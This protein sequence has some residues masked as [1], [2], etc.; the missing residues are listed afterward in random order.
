VPVLKRVLIGGALS[1]R[2]PIQTI[3]TQKA[4]KLLL[5]RINSGAATVT[6]RVRRDA[7]GVP[8]R[9]SKRDQIA[10]LPRVRLSRVPPC[11]RVNP[12]CSATHKTRDTTNRRNTAQATPVM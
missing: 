8:L 2:V 4:R 10:T 7:C 11:S 12:A 5:A 3:G 9:N 1:E 6:P